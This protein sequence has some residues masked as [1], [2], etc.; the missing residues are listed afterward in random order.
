MP[1]KETACTL[2]KRKENGDLKEQSVK[3]NLFFQGLYQVLTLGIPLIITPYLTRTLGAEKLGIYTFIGSI[4]TY[5]VIAANLGISRHG[6]RAITAVSSDKVKLRKTFYGLWVDH[7][8]FSLIA[9]LAYYGVTLWGIRENVVLYRIQGLVVIS[10]LLDVT[11]LF[12]G[13]ENFGSVVIKNTIV[14]LVELVCI[15]SFV[16]SP[17]DLTKYTW[18]MMGSAL[19]GQLIMIPQVLRTV[20][21]IRISASDCILHIKPI[22]VLSISVIAV[23]LYT[24]FDKTLLGF[25]LDMDSVAY[26]ECANRIIGVPKAL[27]GVVGTVFFPRVCKLAKENNDKLKEVF[28]LSFYYT[29][30]IAIGFSVLVIAAARSFAPLF[31]GSGY[32]ATSGIMVGLAPV[33]LIISLGDMV[34]TQ[35]M[36]SKH[37]DRQYIFCVVLNAIVN[38]ALSFSLIPVWGIPGAVVGTVAAETCGLITETFFCREDIAVRHSYGKL[39]P[40]CGIGLISVAPALLLERVLATSWVALF[41]EA[42]ITGFLYLVLSVLYLKCFRKEDIAVLYKIA[43]KREE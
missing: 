12:Y 14:R 1:G 35:L 38:L 39:L 22:L 8:V 3:K 6:Q 5:F 9:V 28:H 20:K 26:Y 27:L 41:A 29:G 24:V 37:K 36:I 23:S 15:F 7:T 13:M 21:P 2:G 34:R 31:F 11:W 10:A 17:E 19:L 25:L 16:H 40:F 4:A 18:I 43:T 32:E 33:I 42:G 30:I